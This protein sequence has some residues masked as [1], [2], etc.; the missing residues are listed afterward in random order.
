MVTI[1]V[2]GIPLGFP[3]EKMPLLEKDLVMQGMSAF[4]MPPE[5]IRVAA[6]REG[7]PFSMRLEDIFS[8][9]ALKA[10]SMSRNPVL[11][12][13]RII[14]AIKQYPRLPVEPGEPVILRR[15]SDLCMIR[16]RTFRA[17]PGC[18]SG[19]LE[20]VLRIMRRNGLFFK[21]E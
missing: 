15:G 20:L 19:M 16:E 8:V 11:M 2:V 12:R 3:E 9:E 6:Y 17:L 14:R 1:V 18:G 13:G 7:Q 10:D 21:P 4:R 5:Q